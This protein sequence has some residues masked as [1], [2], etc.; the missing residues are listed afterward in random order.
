MLIPDD[1][2]VLNTPA[3]TCSANS[4]RTKDD[5]LNLTSQIEFTFK[6]L[7]QLAFFSL[8]NTNVQGGWVTFMFF[9]SALMEALICFHKKKGSIKSAQLCWVNVKTGK[10]WQKSQAARDLWVVAHAVIVTLLSAGDCRFAVFKQILLSLKWGR[11]CDESA[12]LQLP[13]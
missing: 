3:C 1:T 4:Q 6:K 11:G 2:K 13:A 12:S 9:L 5:S 7:P 8:A 10:T